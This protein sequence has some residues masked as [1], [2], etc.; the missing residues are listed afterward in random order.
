MVIQKRQCPI[1]WTIYSFQENYS[2]SDLRIALIQ[3][4]KYVQPRDAFDVHAK[5]LLCTAVKISEC[6]YASCDKRT[7]KTVLQLYNSS[8]LHHK[9]CKTLFSQPHSVSYDK[10]LSSCVSGSW[11]ETM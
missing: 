9:L 10:M 11:T 2:G 6:L 1:Y 5:Q 3:V 7:P 8:W 4:N